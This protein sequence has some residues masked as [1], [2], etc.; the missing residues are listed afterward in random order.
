MRGF[1]LI[2]LF[3]FTGLVVQAQTLPTIELFSVDDEALSYP[4]VEAGT[5]AADFHWRAVGLRDGDRMQLHAWVGGEWALVGEDFA[6]EKTDRLVIAHP[7]DFV[8]PTYRLAVVDA[9]GRI[10]A[11][12]ALELS[13]APP[14]EPPA[15][16][17]FLPFP[18]TITVPE[19]V[20]D[21][22]FHVQ[23]QIE[24]RWFNSNLVFEQILPDGTALNAEL[25]RPV[26]WLPAYRDGYL[27]V[28]YPGDYQDVVLRLRVVNRDDD[29]TLTRQ[30]LVL[31]V[32]N[33]SIP[34]AELIR[35]SV[36]PD[37]IDPGDSVT[38]T[39]AV[40]HTDAVFI[41]YYDG[42]PNGSCAG[43]LETVFDDLPTSGSLEVTAPDIA[44][45]G[46]AFRLFADFHV[47]GDRH[48][49]GSYRDPLAELQVTVTD[50][51]G[52]GVE[53]FTVAPLR[54]AVGQT[55]TLSWAVSEGQSV[56][57]IQ[58]DTDDTLPAWG[59]I[60]PVYETYSGLPLSGTLEVTIPDN[61][62][63]RAA[64]GR[65][66]LLYIVEDDAWPL[67]HDWNAHVVFDRDG[68]LDCDST[69]R[70]G[71]EGRAGPGQASP[72]TDVEVRWD[73]CGQ[74]NTLI[75]Y[76]LVT[77]GFD[78]PPVSETFAPVAPAG[79]TTVT[80]PDEEGTFYIQLYYAHEGERYRL[81]SAAVSLRR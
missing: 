54:T 81:N 29:S 75:R 3:L 33:G 43:T 20:F 50:T 36:T 76:A 39:W 66:F 21:E 4:A 74:A 28:V 53:S 6:P 22:P 27:Q 60:P 68:D 49:C 55:V 78:D 62:T 52:Q 38:V 15:V 2:C 13:Y 14:D 58:P 44:Y 79:T 45:T 24:N 18:P 65:Y 56:T 73:S 63:A 59:E 46:L 71:E 30:E 48:H 67:V 61:P 32:D 37:V 42:L 41:E 7:L 17:M 16:A 19:T 11:E 34:P 80:L 35:F 57:I 69:L 12:Q 72:G 47:G 31:H 64:A 70:V 8:P 25:P 40:A 9:G 51:I 23:W 1:L 77:G 26:E 5:A 10:V